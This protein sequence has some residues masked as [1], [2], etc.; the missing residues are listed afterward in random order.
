MPK[1][2]PEQN[3]F[4]AGEISPKLYGRTDIEA[5]I[6]GVQTMENWIALSHGPAWRRPGFKHL[7]LFEGLVAKVSEFPISTDEAYWVIFTDESPYMHAVIVNGTDITSIATAFTVAFP[8]SA[9][10]IPDLQAELTPE[11]TEL[12]IA[13][14]TQLPHKVTFTNPNTG[15]ENVVKLEG[16]ASFFG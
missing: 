11:G 8:Y 9:S 5:R 7:D 3:S 13:C 1:L 6:A 14:R 4:A 12:Y 2:Y 10:E 15:V 16:L